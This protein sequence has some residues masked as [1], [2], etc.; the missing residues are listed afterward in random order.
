M[1]LCKVIGNV[2]STIKIDDLNYMKL[3]LLRR[4]ACDVINSDVI[5]SIDNVQC[6]IG[7]IVLVLKDGSSA[8]QIMVH[9]IENINDK[10]LYIINSVIVAIVDN[11]NV[12]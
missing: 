8:K 11:V 3:M 12:I 10:R 1:I 6:N 7:D 2:V 4:V 9:Y 5:I